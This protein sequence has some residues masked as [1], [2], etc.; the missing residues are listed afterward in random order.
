MSEKE[1]GQVLTSDNAAEF[2]ANRLGIT[3]SKLKELKKKRILLEKSVLK[4][5]LLILLIAEYF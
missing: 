3:E 4:L 5:V 2:Y 1:A